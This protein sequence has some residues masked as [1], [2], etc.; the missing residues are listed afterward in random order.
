[1]QFLFFFQ[2]ENEIFFSEFIYH[3]KHFLI[4]FKREP[5][6]EIGIEFIAKFSTSLQTGPEQSTDDQT[7]DV[8]DTSIHDDMHPFLLQFFKFLLKVKF[9][10]LLFCQNYVISVLLDDT[11]VL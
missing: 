1:M 6:V 10:P 5:A 9:C 7:T 4:V 8:S 3:V 11:L 2:V